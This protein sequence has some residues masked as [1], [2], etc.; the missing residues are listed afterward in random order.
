[1]AYID[2]LRLINKVATMYY[3]DN[4]RQTDI[5]KQ[6]GLSQAM[7]SRLFNRARE[8]GIVRIS[9][10]TPKGI[11][12]DL[13]K[14]LM[15]RYGLRDAI[16]V[17]CQNSDVEETI[18]RDIGAAASYYVETAINNGEIIGISSWSAT[19]LALVNSMHPVQR[20]KD[21]HVVEI[22]GSVGNPSAEIHAAHITGRFAD[23]VQ[24]QAI[25][26][27]APG[28]VGLKT[29]RDVL[30][31]DPYVHEAMAYFDRITMALVGIGSI[32]PSPIL[33]QSGNIFS[34]EELNLLREKKAVGDISQRF[35]DAEGNPVESSLND[36]VISI[37]LEQMK[38][39]DRAIGMAGGSR[40][41]AAIRAALRGGLINILITDNCTAEKLLSD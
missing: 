13:E 15:G 8:E 12:V 16:V 17:D 10:T 2:E 23:L 22:L 41:L 4:M 38:H 40:K 5:A 6:L 25:Y 34:D 24:G 30:I 28:I 1:M 29:T 33:K 26:L 39:V 11:F 18:Q 19:L 37:E 3:E 27:P 7:V 31:N 9:V 20:K 21:V 32:T 35:F 36:R 14:Q